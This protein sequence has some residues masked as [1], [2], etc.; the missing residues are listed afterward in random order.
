VY[1]PQ[2]QR[3]S[4]SLQPENWATSTIF[5]A[6]LELDNGD[7]VLQKPGVFKILMKKCY[8]LIEFIFRKNSANK[9]AV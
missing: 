3:H 9:N 8:K 4:P 5:H 7:L 6:Q 2:R 1:V